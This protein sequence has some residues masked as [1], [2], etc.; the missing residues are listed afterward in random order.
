VRRGFDDA[1]RFHLGD[2][3]GGERADFN[4]SGWRKLNLPHDW[5]IEQPYSASNPSGN[6]YLPGG[7]GWY[8]KSFAVPEAGSGRRVSIEFDGVYRDSDAW[9]NGHHL[10]HRPYGYSTFEY[11]VTPYL[12]AG[13]ANLVAVRVDHSQAA[14]SRWYT[15]SGIYRHVWLTITGPVHVAHWGTYVRTP[16]SG[17]AEALV[18]VDTAVVND[19]ASETRVRLVTTIEDAAGHEVGTVT[20]EAQLKAAETRSFAQQAVVTNPKLWDLERPELYTAVSRVYADGTAADEYR[21]PF[22]IRNIR[23]DANT[24]F[25]LNGRPEK[26]KGVCIHHDL[27][28]LGAAF[29][30]AALER[31]LKLLKQIGVNAIRCSHN[32]MAPELYAICDRLGLLVMDEGFDEWTLGKNKWV[33]GRNVGT[34]SHDGYNQAFDEWAVRDISDMVLRDRN[35]PSVILWSIGNEIEYPNDPFSHPRGRGGMRPNAPSADQLPPVARRLISAVKLLDGTRPVTEALADIDS[36]NATG[37]AGLLD[38]AGY[39]YLEQNYARDHQAYPERIIL[40]S[41][42][43]HSLA[44]WQTVARNAWVAGQFLWTGV[45]YLGESNRYPDRGSTAGMLDYCG[46]RKPESY[47][48]EALW[49][50]QPMVYAAARE[51]APAGGRG[52]GRLVEHWNWSQDPRKTIPVEVYTRCGSVELSLNGRSLGTKSPPSPLEPLLRWDVPNEAGVVRVL[53]RNDG[54]AGECAHFELATAGAAARLELTA[55]RSTLAPGGGDLA[56]I[57]IHVVDAAGHRVFGAAVPVVVE[58]TGSAELAALDTGDPR[59]VTPVQ[60]GRRNAYQG[61]LLAVVRAGAAP[62]TAAV[63]VSAEGLPAAELRLT[64][65]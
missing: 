7:I 25:Y 35:H 29:N 13:Q 61:R 24:G 5:S 23:F 10:G 47:L 52:G 8:R 11:D 32:P 63:R 42:N 46:F 59:D 16:V 34:P 39:N 17:A 26:L 48:R 30:E 51:A 60:S 41:E 4:D 57:E 65:R 55:D 20:A 58:V 1:W 45:D 49:G 43:S 27:G 18:S 12:K 40:G 15:G 14:D 28:A 64:V 33:Q 38:V 19:S 53:G 50:G 22:G 31:R 56:N 2:V 44:A 36:S 3:T 9:I 21:T 6:G 54:G 37:L 62:G